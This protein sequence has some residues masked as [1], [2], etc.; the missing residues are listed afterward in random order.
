MLYK[1]INWTKNVS[2]S[3]GF[4]KEIKP[5]IYNAGKSTVRANLK[6][7][8]VFLIFSVVVK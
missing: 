7:I 5:S 2:N 1:K 8:T 6:S 3:K 4:F